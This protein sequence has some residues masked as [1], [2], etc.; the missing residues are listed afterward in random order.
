MKIRN[1]KHHLSW[2][3]AWK[4][5]RQERM[6]KPKVSYD[7][8]FFKK[9]AND[10]S[11][12][13]KLNDYEFGR[14]TTEMLD[15]II[16]DNFEVLEIGTGPGTL[17]IPLAKKVKKITGIEFAERNIKNLKLN[18][19]ENNLSNVEIV[20]KKWEEIEDDKIKEKFDL[21]VCSHFLWQ[22]KNIDE[23]L[24]RMENA[25]RSYC[26]II[27]PCGRDEIVK[28]IFEKISN[29]KYTGQFEPDADYF[30]Y[31]IL[32]E[33][34]RLVSVG[35]FDY[36][37]ER[38]LEEQ[39]RNVAGFIGRFYEVDTVLEKKIKDYLLEISE[40]GI[41]REENKAAVLWWQ[42]EK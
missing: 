16:D 15:E 17:T 41:Y 7:D 31:V 36:T 20:N 40:D 3:N 35:Y 8:K 27:Q 28:E 13:I 2:E 37:F 25:S 9:S 14:K 5:M 21:V 23:L 6:G 1:L 30:A 11:E 19:K 33:W 10:F 24:R 42:P 29:Q 34:G 38:N 39:V 4:E 26:S 18:L 12:R 22:I 32:R